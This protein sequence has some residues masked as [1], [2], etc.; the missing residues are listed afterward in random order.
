MQLVLHRLALIV[1]GLRRHLL[2]LMILGK[3]IV[4]SL[5]VVSIQLV[6]DYAGLFQIVHSVRVLLDSFIVIVL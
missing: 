5:E 1:D 3:G 6:P 4:I 2:L